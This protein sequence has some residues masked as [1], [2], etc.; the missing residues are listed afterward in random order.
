[1]SSPLFDACARETA[2]LTSARMPRRSGETDQTRWSKRKR[3]GVS[4]RAEICCRAC[5]VSRP[6]TFT[7]EMRTPFGMRFEGPVEGASAIAAQSTSTNASAPRFQSD[8]RTNDVAALFTSRM[9]RPNR[10]CRQAIT[11]PGLAAAHDELHGEPTPLDRVR[12]RALR[13]HTAHPSRT[14]PSD[15]ARRAMGA[16]DLPFR[17]QKAHSDHARDAAADGRR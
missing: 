13:D 2:A 15:G 1:M 12:A 3:S 9:L 10:R 14:H 16:A 6:E 17:G 8:I 11:A 5:P 4:Y 7:P